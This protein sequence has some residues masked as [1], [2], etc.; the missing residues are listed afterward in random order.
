MAEEKLLQWHAAFYAGIQIELEA[1]AQELVFEQEHMLGTKPMQVDVLIIKKNTEKRIQKNIGRMFKKHNLVEYKSPKDYLS[2]DDFYK[3][4]GYACFYKSDS[5]KVDEI[6]IEEMTITF[7][8]SHYPGKML[9]HLETKWRLRIEK[10]EEGIYYITG[11]VFQIQL[12]VTTRLSE[13][14]NLWLKYLTDDISENTVAEKLLQEYGKHMKNHLYESMMNIIVRANA[15]M[16]QEVRS[17][18][19]ALLELMKDELEAREREV[20]SRGLSQGLSEGLSQG[21]SQ[22]LL[23]G[24]LKK[25]EELVQKKIAKNKTIEQIAEELESDIEEIQPIYNRLK[26]NMV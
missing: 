2:I 12:L 15:E 1:E 10:Q 13:E 22:G 4:L 8:C 11:S 26:E 16:F 21:L 9:R 3:V 18:C 7:V 19:E 20:L 23:Q 6:K 14:N 17:M 5:G 24:S 25:L